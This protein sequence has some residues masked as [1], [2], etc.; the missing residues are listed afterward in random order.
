MSLTGLE[1]FDTTLQK[2]NEWLQQIMEEAGTAN[3]QEA[4]VILR[5][6]LHTLRDR[7]PLEET[8][9][10]GAQFPMLIRGIYYEG[11]RSSIELVK[12]HRDEF[13]DNVFAH[14]VRTALED[15]DPEPAVRAV[16]HTLSRN[17]S[18]GEIQKIIHVL[19]GDLK[20]LW[21]PVGSGKTRVQTA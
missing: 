19:P 11:W 16:F 3:K 20:D 2:T 9:H 17:L 12:M 4:Y 21:E 8:V 18:P 7:L 13:L 10:L 14:F 6:T 15:S 1:V 5:A